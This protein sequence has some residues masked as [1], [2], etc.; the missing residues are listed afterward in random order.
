VA[1]GR[2][3][4]EARAV[5][6]HNVTAMR[7]EPNSRAE[8]TSQ[9]IFGETVR[10]LR[11]EGDYTEVQSPDSYQGWVLTRHLSILETGER[12]PEPSR[13]AMVAPLFLPVFRDPSA[14]SERLML[15]TL[16]TAVELAQGDP[17]ATYYPI[18]LPQGRPGYVEG[19]ALIVPQYPRLDNL[20]PNLV[21]VARGLIGV[22]YL[23]GG[24]TPFGLDC[25]GFVQRVYWLCGHVIPRDAYLQARDERFLPVERGDLKPGDLLFFAGDNDPS[26][27]VI[28]HVGMAMGDGRFV[29]ASGALGVA[30]TP[31]DEAPYD[32]QFWGAR[33]LA[34]AQ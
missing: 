11:D 9:V 18:R 26:K 31:L 22:P 15:L 28:T 33:R 14:Q 25:S 1:E 10:L 12:Y 34:A 2:P 21:I 16:G 5:V 27:R 24:R 3:A 20:G 19:G 23:W 13:A 6:A 29:H 8:Q 32:R 7:A 4:T 30:A 17:D